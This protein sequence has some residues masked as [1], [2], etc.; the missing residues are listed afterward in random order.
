MY[1]LKATIHACDAEALFTSGNCDNVF[2]C[3][4][5]K[6]FKNTWVD[7]FCIYL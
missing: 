3:S 5:K 6:V 7:F 1:T 2:S 4:M